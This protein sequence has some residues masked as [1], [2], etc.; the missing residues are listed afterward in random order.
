MYNINIS[1]HSFSLCYQDIV[2]RLCFILGNM[3]TASPS[4]A[5]KVYHTHQLH[6]SID[7]TLV[8]YFEM[9]RSEK[10]QSQAT[11]GGKTLDVLIKVYVFI[12]KKRIINF[13]W[14]WVELMSKYHLDTYQQHTNTYM[15]VTVYS[16]MIILYMH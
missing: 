8:C 11:S 9:L 14:E 10:N 15:H 13:Q 3:T 6:P 12:C 16:S 4:L 7:K 2:V 5:H 1:F